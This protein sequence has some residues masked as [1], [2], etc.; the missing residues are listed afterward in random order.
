MPE[1]NGNGNKPVGK[2]TYLVLIVAAVIL[3]VIGILTSG[4]D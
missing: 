1:W 3:L 4:G 2:K